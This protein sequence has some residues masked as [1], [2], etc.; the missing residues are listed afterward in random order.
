MAYYVTKPYTAYPSATKPGPTYPP[1]TDRSN[2]GMTYRSEVKYTQKRNDWSLS[3]GNLQGRVSGR[4]SPDITR[5][6]QPQTQ[7]TS[8]IVLSKTFEEWINIARKN[9]LDIKL[10]GS[11]SPFAWVLASTIMLCTLRWVDTKILLENKEEIPVNAI[12]GGQDRFGPLY[13]ARAFV[14]V[15]Y[16]DFLSHYK[17]SSSWHNW[18]GDICQY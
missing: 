5:L 13:I 10:N 4:N 11:T 2:I 1:F 14:E 18:K 9:A 17:R 3:G 15:S 6:S 12:A 16:F 7:V 8:D